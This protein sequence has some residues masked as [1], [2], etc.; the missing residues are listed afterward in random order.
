MPHQIH[1]RAFDSAEK[2]LYERYIP[3]YNWYEDLHFLL[4]DEDSKRVYY[5]VRS[6]M[7]KK[8][9]RTVT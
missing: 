3:I 9:M 6:I 2:L 7:V 4:D 5:R 1:L 8:S